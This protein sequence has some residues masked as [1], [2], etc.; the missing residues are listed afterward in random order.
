MPSEPTG[1]SQPDVRQPRRRSLPPVDT[2]GR[3]LS[4]GIL[5][6]LTWL[7]LSGFF[8]AFLLT[9]GVLS[10]LLVVYIALRMDVADR[11]AHPVHLSPRIIGY[12]FWL[13]KEIWLA[14]ID[15]TKRVLSRKPD[16]SP[17]LVQLKTSQRTELGQVI[18]A[19]SITLTPG[20]FAIRIF[21]DQ[22]LVHALSREGAEALAEGEMDRRVTRVEGET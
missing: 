21:D 7:L 12:W 17:V 4:L 1:P 15:V 11:E 6:F 8:Q 10:C 3:A 19:N 2:T 5:L 9:L 20:T 13:L 18:Y 14:A 22:I 16:I